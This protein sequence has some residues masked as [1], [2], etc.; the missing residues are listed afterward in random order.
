MVRNWMGDQKLV[1]SSSNVLQKAR[2]Y[3]GPS[4]RLQ[5]L[6]PT[7]TGWAHMMGHATPGSNKSKGQ[8]IKTIITLSQEE[9]AT[10]QKKICGLPRCS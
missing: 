8:N 10:I 9:V 4:C 5:S 1:V 7:N 6:A 2:L 3:V